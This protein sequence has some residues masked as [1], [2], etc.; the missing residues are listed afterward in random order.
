MPA[1]EARPIDSGD[2]KPSRKYFSEDGRGGTK[3]VSVR[4]YSFDAVFCLDDKI[5]HL[6]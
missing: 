6:A 2:G 3:P 4:P 1:D 5:R